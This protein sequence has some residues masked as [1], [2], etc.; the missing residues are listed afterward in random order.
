MGAHSSLLI[1]ES[2]ARRIFRQQLGRNEADKVQIETLFDQ[3]LDERL[4]NCVIV[5]DHSTEETNAG[6]IEDAVKEYLADNPSERYRLNDHTQPTDYQQFVALMA[7][8]KIEVT[9]D[10]AC[11]MTYY[12]GEFPTEEV[13]C[14][15]VSGDTQSQGRGRGNIGY[16]SIYYFHRGSSWE[17]PQ[18]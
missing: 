3:A 10:D 7:S 11:D 1:K 13:L 5:S 14:V 6:L 9:L 16:G 18:S 12:N 17:G 2:D 4:Y 8:F 15:G